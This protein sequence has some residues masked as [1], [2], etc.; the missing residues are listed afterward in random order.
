MVDHA[1]RQEK[2]VQ[3]KSI[4]SGFKAANN[5]RLCVIRRIQ[6]TTHAGD[7]SKQSVAVACLQPMKFCLVTSR[8]PTTY[9]P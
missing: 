2:P 9:D 1:A 7:Q 6:L 4:P 8:Q 3:P 5:E